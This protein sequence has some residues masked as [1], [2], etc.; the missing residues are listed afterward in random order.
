MAQQAFFDFRRWTA[1]RTSSGAFSWIPLCKSS[2]LF[3][4]NFTLMVLTRACTITE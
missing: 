4:M 1:T 3:L 2:L